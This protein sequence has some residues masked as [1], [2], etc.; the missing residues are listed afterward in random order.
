MLNVY[1]C[2]I[3]FV[4]NFR[5]AWTSAIN[6][7]VCPFT[8]KCIASN[9]CD[10]CTCYLQGTIHLPRYILYIEA[11]ANGM[12][13]VGCNGLINPPDET[14]QFPLVMAEIA[15]F[16][17]NVFDLLMDLTVLYDMSK[18]CIW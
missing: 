4:E 11:A 7:V 18:V 9:V 2:T 5:T 13:G 12:F 6:G 8:E 17:Q 14:K 3:T 10:S 15:I 1:Y 16:D